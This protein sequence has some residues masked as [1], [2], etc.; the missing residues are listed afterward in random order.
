V[1]YTVEI[2]KRMKDVFNLLIEDKRGGGLTNLA[3]SVAEQQFI[4]RILNFSSNVT[5]KLN[6]DKNGNERYASKYLGVFVVIVKLDN[7]EELII[8][9]LDYPKPK[10]S[11]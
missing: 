6:A 3:F 5:R 11:N 7:T 1:A 10:K 4:E 2:S 9:H 8:E